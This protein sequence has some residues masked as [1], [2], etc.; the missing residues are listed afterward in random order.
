M[1]DEMREIEYV[2]KTIKKVFESYGYDPLE[3]LRSKAGIFLR[4]NAEKRLKGRF[5]NLRTRR[6]ENSV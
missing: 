2:V 6:G 4:L 1:P 3:T 5:T